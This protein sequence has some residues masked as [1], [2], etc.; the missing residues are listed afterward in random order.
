MLLQ[1]RTLHARF[2]TLTLLALVTGATLAVTGCGG[3]V[4]TSGSGQPGAGG[5]PSQP[6]PA[7]T[8]GACVTNPTVGTLATAKRLSPGLALNDSSVFFSNGFAPETTQRVSRAGNTT[9]SVVSMDGRVAAA[10]EK[11]LFLVTGGGNAADYGIVRVPLDGSAPVTLVS[12]VALIRDVVVDGPN[13][14]WST[15]GTVGDLCNPCPVPVGGIYSV[16]RA[17]GATK[18]VLAADNF[19]PSTLAMDDASIYWE[20]QTAGSTPAANTSIGKVGK[21]GSAPTALVTTKDAFIEQMVLDADHIYWVQSDLTDTA[22][23]IIASVVKS[24]GAPSTILTPTNHYH[25]PIAVDSDNLYWVD[26]SA[27]SIV[28]APKTGGMSSFVA[29][30]GGSQSSDNVGALVADASGLYWTVNITC[31]PDCEGSVM[32]LPHACK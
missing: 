16:P 6:G 13:V 24:G 32:H 17:G 21:D 4:T 8:G 9:A 28:K 25:G 3:S 31:G 11:D 27:H 1:T 12:N 20:S 22:P 19:A 2:S 14:Y 18:A 15:N 10:D 26:D 5:D 7:P 30:D 29:A 23:T